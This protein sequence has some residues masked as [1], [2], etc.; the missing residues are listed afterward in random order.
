MPYY[1]RLFSKSSETASV[2]QLRAS[3][4][5][6]F[7]VNVTSGPEARWKEL[8]VTAIDGREVC[9]VE[10]NECGRDDLAADEIEEFAEAQDDAE[11]RPAAK[12][13]KSYLADCR[14][15]YACQFLRALSDGDLGEVPSLVMWSIRRLVGGIGQTDGEGFSNEEGYQ[16]TWDFSDNVTGSW[17]MAVLVSPDQWQH[18]EMDLGDGAHRAAFRAGR[19]TDGAKSK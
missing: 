10:R 7:Y 2:D 13:I 11:P 17:N 9:L 1:T 4:P 14:S 19:V 3:L 5:N 12:W 18:F 6:K 8:I 16:V 15:V